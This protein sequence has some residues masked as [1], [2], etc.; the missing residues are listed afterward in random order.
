MLS[1]H[2]DA[3]DMIY[4]YIVY[5]LNVY[6]YIFSIIII[7]AMFFLLKSTLVYPEP[8]T[9]PSKALNAVPK[10]VYKN[11]LGEQWMRNKGLIFQRTFLDS[12]DSLFIDL[13]NWLTLAL[14]C[15]RLVPLT[16]TGTLQRSLSETR[17]W[18]PNS[19]GEYSHANKNKNG[20]HWRCEFFPHYKVWEVFPCLPLQWCKRKT[21]SAEDSSKI[22]RNRNKRKAPKG[23]KHKAKKIPS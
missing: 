1:I 13:R 6:S 16:W 9:T 5:T 21:S 15:A 18:G 8:G 23:E 4:N 10:T 12:H 14:N 2:A 19:E 22:A 20:D 7:N 11:T 3:C 17:N